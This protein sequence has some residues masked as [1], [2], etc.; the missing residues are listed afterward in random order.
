M[1]YENFPSAE[2]PKQATPPQKNNNMRNLLT[3]GLLLA[4]LGTWGYIIYDKNQVHEKDI[5]QD[6][7]LAKTTSDKD[8]LRREL[9]H[10]FACEFFLQAN[11]DIIVLKK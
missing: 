9:D 1:A 5:K 7:Q 10:S 11:V 2:T 6:E 4:L 8:E 3:G